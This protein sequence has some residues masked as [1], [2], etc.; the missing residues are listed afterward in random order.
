M[1]NAIANISA[2]LRY[3][4]VETAILT[5]FAAACA[6][7]AAQYA[8]APLGDD[9]DPASCPTADLQSGVATVRPGKKV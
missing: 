4:A 6:A 2:A 7:A 8:D 1:S 5:S 9:A 3:D